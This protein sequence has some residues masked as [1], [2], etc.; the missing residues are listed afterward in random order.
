[1][2]S[3]PGQYFATTVTPKPA[4]RRVS[5]VWSPTTPAPR[6]MISSCLDIVLWVISREAA[7]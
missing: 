5:A 7:G 2:L 3:S 4:S 1:M 6:T